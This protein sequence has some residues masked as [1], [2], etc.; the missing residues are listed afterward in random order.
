MNKTSC[1]TR[2]AGFKSS[3][4]TKFY[5]AVAPIV[6]TI[7]ILF[8]GIDKPLYDRY[9][10]NFPRLQQ[11]TDLHAL[12]FTKRDCWPT[13]GLL[14]NWV[15]APHFDRRD[16]K[17]GY[18]CDTVTGSFTGGELVVPEL[19]VQIALKPD[20]VL[21]M[22]SRLLEHFLAPFRGERYAFIYFHHQD[23]F[24]TPSKYDEE[25][26]PSAEKEVGGSKKDL[27][28]KEE[29]KESVIEAE[30]GGPETW[31][32]KRRRGQVPTQI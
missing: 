13:L 15:V 29:E 20:D 32:R 4:A 14:I 1:Q 3:A 9:C 25:Q 12:H 31:A 11:S 18:V 28:E 6:Q 16:A 5:R 24:E 8:E 27:E 26:S 19:G 30:A 21:F 22:R 23:L 2:S 7:G 17:D 10:T